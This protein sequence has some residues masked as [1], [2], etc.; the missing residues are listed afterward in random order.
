MLGACRVGSPHKLA[1]V[2]GD[3]IQF[4][5]TWHWRLLLLKSFGYATKLR[6]S[7]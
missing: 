7:V 4:F 3:E 1:L 6:G 5:E 2:G